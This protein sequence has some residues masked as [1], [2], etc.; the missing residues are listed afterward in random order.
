MI[1]SLTKYYKTFYRYFKIDI[2]LLLLIIILAVFSLLI[3][4]SSSGESIDMV[5]RQLTR[6]AIA[7]IVMIAV[8]QIPPLYLNRAAPTLI[9]VGIFLLILVLF[10]GSSG[11]GAQRWLNLGFIKFQPSE[12][13][14]IIVPISIASILSERTLP[15]RPLM[16]F[17]S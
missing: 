3:L 14:K 16:G 8:S 4:Y 9:T 2:P 11:G 5:Y 10:F 15:P 17:I 12:M 1:S 7:T 13:M 6:F